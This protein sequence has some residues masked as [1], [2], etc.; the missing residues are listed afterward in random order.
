METLWL[1]IGGLILILDV[2]QHISRSV[3]RHVSPGH[4]REMSTSQLKNELI[5]SLPESFAFALKNK[6]LFVS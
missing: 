5:R 1:H 3:C 6:G 2:E 4:S